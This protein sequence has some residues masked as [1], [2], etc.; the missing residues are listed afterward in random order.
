LKS[1]LNARAIASR[2]LL[3]VSLALVAGLGLLLTNPGEEEFEHFAAAQLTMAAVSELC[4][5][6]AL[7]AMARLVLRDCPGLVQSQRGLLGKLALAATR[8]RNFGLFSVYR[9][10]LGG[11][12]VL[13]NWS[14]PR[15]ST[16]TLAAAGRFLLLSSARREG[17]DS[18]RLIGSG[19]P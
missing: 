11:Q 3:G 5:E 14:I 1:R 10:E 8:R 4:E 19:D 17:E 15:Y 12:R 13:A 18:D 7:P 2:S 9:T 6:A 16:L